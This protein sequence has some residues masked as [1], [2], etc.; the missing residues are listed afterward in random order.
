[1]RFRR[2]GP[3]SMLRSPRLAPPSRRLLAALVALCVLLSG[4]APGVS[5]A[6]AAAAP[7]VPHD[8]CVAGGER[9]ETP[10]AHHGGGVDEPA[11]P[12]CAVHGGTHAAPPCVVATFGPPAAAGG[13]PVRAEAPAAGHGVRIAAAPR[14]PPVPARSA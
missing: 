1:M 12:L 13:S 11:C 2:S 4:V 3:S 7:A 10:P 14:G 6:L 9:P 5:R 8:L